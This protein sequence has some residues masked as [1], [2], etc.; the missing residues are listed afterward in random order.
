MLVNTLSY[1]GCMANHFLETLSL[2][3]SASCLIHALERRNG[4][5]LVL[6][7][8]VADDLTV[9][10]VDLAVGL[11]LEGEGVLHPVDVVTVGE[12]LAGVGTTRFLTVSGSGGSLG[13]VKMVS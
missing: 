10:Q 7:E 5:A 3:E 13:A 6:V 11:L 2:L 8:G 4:R 1:T 9:R 12:I